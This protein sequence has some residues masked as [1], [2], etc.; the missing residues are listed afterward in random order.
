MYKAVALIPARSGSKRIKNKNIFK[1]NKQPLLAYT[2]NAAIKSKMFQRIICVTDNKFYARIAKKFGAEVPALRPK[3]ISGEKSSDIEWLLWIMKEINGINKFDI[4]S[5]LRPTSPLRNS[6]TIK[7]AFNYFIRNKSYDSLRAI[8]KCKQHP[9]KM[10]LLKKKRLFPLLKNLK[11]SKTPMHSQQYANLPIVF[12]QNAS[13]E[14]AW[15]RILKKKNPT[16]SG[17]KIL[18][19]ESIGWEGFDINNIEDIFLLKYLLQKKIIKLTL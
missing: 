6:K 15:T 8:N 7:R 17:N 13:L 11:N 9:A 12:T 4:F 5:I 19:F 14:I 2:I 16:I 18:G 1:V 10:W 3:K